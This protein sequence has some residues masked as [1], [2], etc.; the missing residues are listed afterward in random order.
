MQTF[1]NIAVGDDC[2]WR[3]VIDGQLKDK[4][5]PQGGRIKFFDIEDNAIAYMRGVDGSH[6]F[7]CTKKMEKI[8]GSIRPKLLAIL[9]DDELC[10][11]G[12]IVKQLRLPTWFADLEEDSDRR[13]TIIK[14]L[15]NFSTWVNNEQDDH[16]V[17]PEFD[18]ALLAK[19]VDKLL[20]A[21]S[22]NERAKIVIAC[23]RQN[24]EKAQKLLYYALRCIPVKL[25]NQLTFNTAAKEMASFDIC[26]G[27]FSDAEVEKCGGVRIDIEK[28]LS[29]R[30][31]V[32]ESEPFNNAYADYIQMLSVDSDPCERF[33]DEDDLDTLNATVYNEVLEVRGNKLTVKCKKNEVTVE[34][35]CDFADHAKGCDA[36]VKKQLHKIADYLCL[37]YIGFTNCYFR[38]NVEYQDFY[39]SF[40][41]DKG[42]CPNWGSVENT[43]VLFSQNDERCNSEYI[44]IL[45]DFWIGTK[46]NTVYKNNKT[47]EQFLFLKFDERFQNNVSLYDA[48]VAYWNSLTEDEFLEYLSHGTAWNTEVVSDYIIM[49]NGEKIVQL[50]EYCCKLKAD[51]GIDSGI[52]SKICNKYLSV[53]FERKSEISVDD[54]RIIQQMTTENGIILEACILNDIQSKVD[55]ERVRHRDQVIDSLSKNRRIEG[56]AKTKKR[57]RSV[58]KNYLKQKKKTNRINI[59]DEVVAYNIARLRERDCGEA[60]N[61]H[62]AD[63]GGR[64]RIVAAIVGI[65]F[66]LQMIAFLCTDFLLLSKL[67]IFGFGFWGEFGLTVVMLIIGIFVWGFSAKEI[68]SQDECDHGQYEIK[69]AKMLNRLFMLCSVGTVIKALLAI[70][71]VVL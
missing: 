61:I 37:N 35:L 46:K 55:D 39:E 30:S 48:F 53:L 43:D 2:R 24:L 16:W 13:R 54:L 12:R 4:N 57:D 5:P 26:C 23:G 3:R 19:I 42:R 66:A 27:N 44:K 7:L 62:N 10:F 68:W 45:Y 47:I 40:V 20:T 34:E 8:V 22:K 28:V 38:L 59:D 15:P 49:R 31:D 29:D 6:I 14:E 25:A 9:N 69:S 50:V 63:W 32:S 51:K 71:F 65:L 56:L 52:V 64:L 67:Y 17:A 21:V 58:A 33:Y 41:T 60:G 36:L 18:M 70:L 11:S 1:I